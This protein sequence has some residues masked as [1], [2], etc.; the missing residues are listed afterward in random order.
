MVLP[1][2]GLVLTLIVLGGFASLVTLADPH[3]ASFAP[4]A[5]CMFWAG[6]GAL[7]LSLGLAFVGREVLHSDGFEGF[8]FF[9]GY[10]LGGVG[11]GLLGL[12][13][14]SRRRRRIDR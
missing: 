11:G 10:A 14:A 8:G 7:C 4:L 2:M 1:M 6:L 5:F 9:G 13:I 12:V 3:R